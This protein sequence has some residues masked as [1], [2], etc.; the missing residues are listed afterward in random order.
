MKGW[1]M[2]QFLHVNQW[3]CGAQERRIFATSNSTVINELVTRLVNE[4]AAAVDESP[5]NNVSI[6]K[7]T[8]HPLA[9]AFTAQV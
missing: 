5:V 7:A 1:I 2:G 9:M 8:H 6:I 3:E 4:A